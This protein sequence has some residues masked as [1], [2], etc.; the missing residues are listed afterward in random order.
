MVVGVGIYVKMYLIVLMS[1][2]RSNIFLKLFLFCLG[3]PDGDDDYPLDESPRNDNDNEFE[4]AMLHNRNQ[5]NL[6]GNMND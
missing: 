6:S 3:S 4:E 1:F 5:L 2:T